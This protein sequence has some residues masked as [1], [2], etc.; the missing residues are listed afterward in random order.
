MVEFVLEF[1][2][3]FHQLFLGHGLLTLSSIIA[4]FKFGLL[5]LN[6]HLIQLDLVFEVLDGL[7]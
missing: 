5:N 7:L 1:G 4:S 6:R 3:L 2:I